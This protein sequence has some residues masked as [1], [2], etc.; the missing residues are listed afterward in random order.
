MPSKSWKNHPQKLL[1]IPQIHFFSLLPWVPK[2]PKQKN[3]CYE[4]WPI[5]QLCIKLGFWQ[6]SNSSYFSMSQNPSA[7]DSESIELL[8]VLSS[9]LKF[10]NLKYCIKA[11]ESFKS[12]FL[13]VS[14]LIY[15]FKN[16]PKPLFVI[17]KILCSTLNSWIGE[18]KVSCFMP[19]TD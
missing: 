19:W 3:S 18:F 17:L 15:Y 4:M 16:H 6:I 13:G 11:R 12:P 9:K 8:C 14:F 10:M 7:I 1:K 5:D 2:W